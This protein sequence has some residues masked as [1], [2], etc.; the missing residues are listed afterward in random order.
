[1]H[2]SRMRVCHRDPPPNIDQLLNIARRSNAF[3]S[4]CFT[5]RKGHII[6]YSV[7]KYSETM[8]KHPNQS[9][10]ETMSKC[11]IYRTVL[12]TYLPIKVIQS[13]TDQ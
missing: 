12:Q 13:Y 5:M 1:M 7:D 9:E 3:D 8:L 2:S 6:T 11:D 10:Q 4:D